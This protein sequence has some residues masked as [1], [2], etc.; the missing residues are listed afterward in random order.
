MA[1]LATM[2]PTPPIDA[3][4]TELCTIRPT[5]YGRGVFACRP[6]PAGTLIHSCLEPYASVIYREFRKEVCGYC[7]K[8][9]F[10]EGTNTW[11]VRLEEGVKIGGE[12]NVPSAGVWFCCVECRAKWAQEVNVDG[13]LVY[14]NIAVAKAMKRMKKLQ[15]A[16]GKDEEEVEGGPGPV[17][18]QGEVTEDKVDKIWAEAEKVALP[19]RGADWETLQELELENARFLIS[20]ILQRHKEDSTGCITKKVE[21]GILP[22]LDETSLSWPGVLQLQNNEVHYIRLRPH[23]LSSYIRI[24]HFLRRLFFQP[25]SPQLRVLQKYVSESDTC[26]AILS[27]D[28]GNVF[29]L[30]E[31][32][33]S[34]NGNSEM[35]G[36]GMYLSASYF[37]H[38]AILSTPSLDVILRC[39]TWHYP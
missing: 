15:D 31:L 24:Y 21:G 26:R 6:I 16:N 37:N 30:W 2:L 38:G 1:A 13:L 25:T 33:T 20:G 8:Y 10:D 18:I 17:L 14:A 23:A 12:G 5:P 35:L 36:W 39:L 11:N 34:S 4:T 28:P 32:S 29:G 19:G 27:R 9:A 7:F 22:T 3:P